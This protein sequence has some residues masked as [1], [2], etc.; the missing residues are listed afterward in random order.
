MAAHLARTGGR[1]RFRK[2]EPYV[3][4]VAGSRPL[5]QSGYPQSSRGLRES[6]N[7]VLPRAFVEVG[8]EKPARPVGEHRINAHHLLAAEVLEKSRVVHGPERLLRAVAALHFRQLADSGDEFVRAS[9]R[10]AGLASLL[11]D[12]ASRIDIVAPSEKLS[13]QLHLLG[14]RSRYGRGGWACQGA[15]E[16]RRGEHGAE[17]RPARVGFGWSRGERPDGLYLRLDRSGNRD[18]FEPIG[19]R[20]RGLTDFDGHGPAGRCRSRVTN[21]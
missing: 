5:H 7:V 11:A 18:P 4:A 14:R 10:V 12:E 13:E 15:D 2:E 20:R 17:L 21:S 9:G 1:D 16:G 3:R 19:L 8:G 6:A